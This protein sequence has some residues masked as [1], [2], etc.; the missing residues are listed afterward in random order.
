MLQ[1]LGQSDIHCGGDAGI[2]C[3]LNPDQRAACKVYLGDAKVLE[4]LLLM[5]TLSIC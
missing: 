5:D 2:S 3:S 1:E 4:C